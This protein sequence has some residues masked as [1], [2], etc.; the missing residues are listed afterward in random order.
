LVLTGLARHILGGKYR[1]Q[2]MLAR[3]A[4]PM[5]AGSIAGAILGGYA[6]LCQAIA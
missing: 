6:A 3:L 2:T 1:S 4:I 5:S